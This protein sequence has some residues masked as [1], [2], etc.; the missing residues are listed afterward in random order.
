MVTSK[1]QSLKQRLI[2]QHHE[3]IQTLEDKYI[4]AVS[5][6]LE[7]KKVIL[8]EMQTQLYRQLERIDNLK[9]HEYEQHNL[10]ID[11]VSVSSDNETQDEDEHTAEACFNA[12]HEGTN[13]NSDQNI[14]SK[15]IF[16]LQARAILSKVNINESKEE[17]TSTQQSS[18]PQ[19]IFSLY[20]EDMHEND[21]ANKN[22]RVNE[23]MK[24]NINMNLSDDAYKEKKFRKKNA[25]ICKFGCG[26][27][28]TK[29]SL[30]VH[31]RIHTGERPFE[32]NVCHKRFRQ[33]S[34]FNN[35]YRI[36]TGEKPFKCDLCDYASTTA[37]N[38]KAHIR[39]HKP[40]KKYECKYCGD[41]FISKTPLNSHMKNHDLH[42]C[43]PYKCGKCDKAFSTAYYRNKHT[44]KCQG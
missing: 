40:K 37:G 23:K 27:F 24:I 17:F 10:S 20:D 5:K 33:R 41:S 39:R 38:L 19:P 22:A 7:Q 16:S 12:I 18:K 32:C 25:W 14:D 26:S 8:L 35:H 21:A 36:H 28:A 43:K 29:Q 44:S 34:A 6:L 15:P 4:D 3:L 31:T 11:A 2:S 1:L 30:K 13:T 42:A 9:Q